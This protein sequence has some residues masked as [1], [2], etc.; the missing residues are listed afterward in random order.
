LWLQG[1]Q[2]QGRKAKVASSKN[3]CRV[4]SVAMD[5]QSRKEHNMVPKVG[6]SGAEVQV[7]Y[8]STMFYCPSHS[9]ASVA[10]I[11]LVTLLFSPEVLSQP[12]PTAS[13]PATRSPVAST[14][15]PTIPQMP[16]LLPSEMPSVRKPTEKPVRK[17][18]EKPVFNANSPSLKPVK[19]DEPTMVNAFE[20]SSVPSKGLNS[21]TLL[22]SLQPTPATS[23]AWPIVGM[24][25]APPDPTGSPVVGISQAPTVANATTGMPTPMF[26][27]TKQPTMIANATKSVL[28]EIFIKLSSVAGTMPSAVVTAYESVCSKFFGSALEALHPSAFQVTARLVEQLRLPLDPASSG[29]QGTRALRTLQASMLVPLL[30]LV[31]VTGKVNGSENLTDLNEILLNSLEADPNGFVSMLK[32]LPGDSGV[33]FRSAKSVEEF[34]ALPASPTS[35]P[36]DGGGGNNDLGVPVAVFA[37]FGGFLTLGCIAFAIRRTYSDTR[38]IGTASAAFSSAASGSKMKPVRDYVPTAVETST[39]DLQETDLQECTGERKPDAP[40]PSPMVR[41]ESNV[42]ASTV[43]GASSVMEYSEAGDDSYTYSL[44]AGNVDHQASGS[45]LSDHGAFSS[46]EDDQSTQASARPNLVSR[47]IVAP[48]GKLGIIVDTTL[49]GPVVHVVNPK[50]PLQGIVEPGDIIVA[51]GDVDARA[52]SAA[53]ITALM[54]KTAGN[55]RIFTILREE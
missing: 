14:P 43:Q 26:P 44:E 27:P 42:D 20:P 53:D 36:I 38:G 9:T 54:I 17:P 41:T 7:L 11:V 51:I 48:S 5:W 45:V 12:S 40:G 50:S 15:F 3:K 32:A 33:Y 18:T 6:R 19:T 30:T 46:L 4:Q 21:P 34:A 16:S 37:A 55:E 1:A 24:A 13:R 29:N 10:L 25:P 28:G 47:V 39:T 35:A 31:Q 22:L 8:K 23:S 52:M 2:N 49:E